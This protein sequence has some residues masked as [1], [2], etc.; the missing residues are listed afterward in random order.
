MASWQRKAGASLTSPNVLCKIQP[1]GQALPPVL[2]FF[3]ARFCR[4]RALGSQPGNN[5]LCNLAVLC[6]RW[7]MIDDAAEHRGRRWF[8]VFCAR[9][10]RNLFAK[11]SAST[12]I[13]QRTVSW[14]FTA[15]FQQLKTV[16]RSRPRSCCPLQA[17][18][19]PVAMLLR[20]IATRG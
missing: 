18:S 20:L 3:R 6:Q 4:K 19:I 7:R 14:A 12:L 10:I 9:A 15:S 17:G 2:Q 16:L 13:V 1:A 8:N 11:G 5:R